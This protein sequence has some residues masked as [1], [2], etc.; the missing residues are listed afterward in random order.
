MHVPDPLIPLFDDGVIQEVIRPLMSGK[1]ASVYVVRAREDICVAKVYKESARKKKGPES[2]HGAFL[3][4]VY[5]QLHLLG[6]AL[7][8]G[9]A[10]SY[11]RLRL[12]AD[13]RC[14]YTSG[15]PLRSCMPL[16]R[17]LGAYAGK[18][19]R[20]AR[21]PSRC[22]TSV[23]LSDATGARACAKCYVLG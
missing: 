10:L 2:S 15:R 5:F 12:R 20:R 9:G 7:V 11:A 4:S 3:S 13:A 16:T 23:A 22:L 18:A 6:A 19:K 21:G 8:L 14:A 17:P 1:E